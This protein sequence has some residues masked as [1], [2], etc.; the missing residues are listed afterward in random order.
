MIAFSEDPRPWLARKAF[1]TAGFSA[2]EQS[3]GG[4]APKVLW[5]P[6][7]D[8]VGHRYISHIN[9]ISETMDP[10]TKCPSFPVLFLDFC[11][12]LHGPH[13]THVL[14]WPKP[15]PLQLVRFP[16]TAPV[17]HSRPW[18]WRSME[19]WD[20]FRWRWSWSF[21]CVCTVSICFIHSKCFHMRGFWKQQLPKN[22]CKNRNIKKKNWILWMCHWDHGP[23]G[24]SAAKLAARHRL[25]SNSQRYMIWGPKRIVH[26]Q[27]KKR[28]IS[29]NAVHH[30]ILISRLQSC[31]DLSTLKTYLIRS[32]VNDSKT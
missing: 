26:T 30:S 18:R 17:C 27:S 22:W 32:T 3:W 13:G 16:A 2:E 8:L 20:D 12:S 7:S 23:A 31:H 24:Y 4:I 25:R 9:P 15:P 1:I 21:R 5:P 11:V 19:R 28:K 6:I 10:C 14:P 29:R